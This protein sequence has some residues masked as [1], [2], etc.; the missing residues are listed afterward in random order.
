MYRQ[1]ELGLKVGSGQV[2]ELAQPLALAAAGLAASLW[3]A[4]VNY[5]FFHTAVE[6]FSVIVAALTCVLALASSRYAR[7]DL[8]L[9]IGHAHALVG[10]IDFLHTMAYKGMC[11]LPLPTPDTATQLW[12]AGRYIWAAMFLMAPALASGRLPRRPATA[13]LGIVAVALAWS[14]LRGGIF[15]TCFIEGSGLTL[16]KIVSEYSVITAVIAG[17]LLLVRQR[18]TIDDSL[19]RALMGAAGATVVSEFCFTLYHDVYG[20]ANFLGHI[21]KVVAYGF[22]FRGV[23]LRGLQAPY[24]SIF[25]ELQRSAVRDSLT[26]LY[27]RFGFMQIAQREMEAAVGRPDALIGAL[28]ADLDKFKQV[29]DTFGHLA[30]D[31]VLVQFARILLASVGAA[32]TVARLGGDEF[33]VLLPG[34]DAQKASAVAGIIKQQTRAWTQRSETAAGLDVSIGMAVW[35]PHTG[36]DLDTLLRQADDAMYKEKEL[37]RTQTVFAGPGP[38]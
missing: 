9:F 34:A 20:T 25:A 8:L 30:G 26:G 12:I 15:P 3:A 33:V 1:T 22:L 27:N 29:N 32:D 17:S 5:L 31:S 37:K 4:R 36:G 19:L 10:A 38:E 16:F 13:A 18:D 11:V 35:M 7:S 21:F 2:R 28:M 23:V 24:D 14:I 6:N